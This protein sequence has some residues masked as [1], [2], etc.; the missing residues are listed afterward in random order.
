MYER[1]EEQLK[2]YK[3]QIERLNIPNNSLDQAIQK[4][5]KKAKQQKSLT[6]RNKLLVG[7]AIVAIVLIGCVASI[8]FYELTKENK[9]LMSAIE[10]DYFEEIGASEKKNGLRVTIDGAIADTNGIVL[11]Y[12]IKSDTKE[13][14]LFMENVQLRNGQGEQLQEAS[15]SYGEPHYSEKGQKKYRGKIEYFF[16]DKLS[17]TDFNLHFEIVGQGRKDTFHIPF[18]LHNELKKDVVYAMNKVVETNGQKI[19]ISKVVI[20]PLRAAV[21]M[22]YDPEN[23]KKLVDFPDLHLVNEDGEIWGKLV[24]GLTTRHIDEHEK[25]IYLQSNYFK[26]PEKLYLSFKRIQ[27]I[28]KSESS[29]VVDLKEEKVIK[30]PSGNKFSEFQVIGNELLF[31]MGPQDEF[32]FGLFGKVMDSNNKELNVR[33]MGYH[34]NTEEKVNKYSVTIE[35]LSVLQS[36]ITLELEFYPKWIWIDEDIQLRIK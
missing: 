19:T 9:G 33:S 36:P 35:G 8:T 28:N 3:E 30:Q 22:K 7:F 31:T 2:K 26:D 5:F 23:T 21:H 10:H 12:T 15:V 27:A 25:I 24:N 20:S 16:T 14:E 6:G 32:P 29:V 34:F 1:E 13:K 18:S 11:F 17:T 4:G